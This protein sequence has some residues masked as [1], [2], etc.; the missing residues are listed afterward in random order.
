MTIYD[1]KEIYV[2]EYYQY[3]KEREEYNKTALKA[4]YN[5]CVLEEA[6]LLQRLVPK[7]KLEYYFVVYYYLLWNGYFS[8]AN[9]FTGTYRPK[10]LPYEIGISI[11]NG[12]GCCRN[13]AVHFRNILHLLTRSNDIILVGTNSINRTSISKTPYIKMRRIKSSDDIDKEES[14]IPSHIELLDFAT[15]LVYDPTN[16]SVGYLKKQNNGMLDLGVE[17]L[18]NYDLDE[19]VRQNLIKYFRTIERKVASWDIEP[20]S[21]E[22]LK[23]IRQVGIDI[24]L[25]NLPLLAEFQK[26][27]QHIYHYIKDETV[28]VLR[29]SDF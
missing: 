5:Q 13:I 1:K 14:N 15:K 21:K 29:K 17:I 22:K 18:L 28:K 20:Y 3:K 10:E 27:Q 24:C 16:F 9:H 19:D 26:Q 12:T 6:K 2:N 23:Q 11:A 4:V 8:F 7:Q 25:A